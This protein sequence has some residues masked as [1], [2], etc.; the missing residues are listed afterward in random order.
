VRA[1]VWADTETDVDFLNYSEI[2]E[3]IADLIAD[4]RLLPLSLGVFG[5]WGIGKSSTLNLTERILNQTPDKYLIVRFDAW[6]YQDFDDARAALMSVI[7]NMLVVAAPKG[8]K[9]RAS[10]LLARVDK[11]RLLGFLVEGGAAAFGFPA[12]G[13][14]GRLV[15][16]GG[17]AL[18]GNSD[19]E[20][21]AKLGEAAESFEEKAGKLLKA[22]EGKQP[23][24]EIADFRREFGEVLKGLDK[25]LVVFIDNLDRCL[26]PNTIHTLEAIRLV[27]FLPKT[28]FV[29][30]ADEDMVRHAVAQHFQNPGERHVTDYLDKLIQMPVFVPR[31]GVLE[32]SAYLTLLQAARFI[33]D[34]EKLTLLREFLLEELR[35]SW[36]EGGGFTADKV[37]ELLGTNNEEL[38]GQIELGLRMA[39]M[40]AQSARVNGNPRIVK[41]LMNVVRMRAS[42]AARRKMPLDEGII[43]KLALFERCTDGPASQTLQNAIQAAPDGRPELLDQVERARSEEKLLQACPETWKRHIEVIRDWVR[44]EPKLAGV[45][46]RPAVYL[47]RE[48]VPMRLGTT[49][50]SPT[51]RAAVE[52]LLKT[53]TLGSVAAREAAERIDPAEALPAMDEIVSEMR[54]NSEWSRNRADVRGAIVLARSSGP[55]AEVL[56]RF[57]RSL[58]DQ[59]RWL[60]TMIDGESWAEIG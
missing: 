32:I 36:R 25:T 24:Q 41:R 31:P 12:F 6:L 54:K 38:R 22:A 48:T 49:G 35:H 27:L 60:K 19:D 10:G 15:E 55:A 2:A 1:F 20:E 50:L 33:E 5:G 4:E 47:S 9:D 57:L 18:T 45:D 16:A 7:A 21:K 8:L 23:A 28:A 3:L 58:P 34:S 51:A 13:A 11:L 40:L 30:A 14:A 43:A 59:P 52:E 42:I 26:P 44:L 39:P 37:M 53:P 46:L 29:I 17:K 56:N